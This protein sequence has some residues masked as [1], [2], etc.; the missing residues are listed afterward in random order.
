M[1]NL[2]LIVGSVALVTAVLVMPL[3]QSILAYTTTPEGD[4]VRIKANL[5]GIAGLAGVYKRVV[6]VR[7]VG[8]SP[9]GRSYPARRK[10][11]VT[12]ERP[13]GQCEERIVWISVALFGYGDLVVD[14]PS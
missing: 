10:Y 12:L 1:D 13:D 5:S 2:I 8:G 3:V 14:G 4:L 9:A 7:R 6:D 11:L